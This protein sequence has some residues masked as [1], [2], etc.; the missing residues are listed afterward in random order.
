MNRKR[1]VVVLELE[2]YIYDI[3]TM[4]LLHTLDTG[5]NPSAICALSPSNDNSYLAYPAPIP[6][7]SSPLSSEQPPASSSQS[8]TIGSIM[9]FDTISLTAINMIQAHK[10]AIAAMAINSQGTMLATAS[11]KGTV[12][13]VFSV[14]D[15]KKLGEY[16]RGSKSAR[17]FSMN[18]NAVGSLLAVSSDTETVHVYNLLETSKTSKS[19]SGGGSSSADTHGGI[20]PHSSPASEAPSSPTLSRSGSNTDPLHHPS[21]GAQNPSSSSTSNAASSFSRRSF[22]LGKNLVAGMGGYLPNR[23]TEVWEPRRDFA[24]C[25][26]RGG[27]GGRSVVAMSP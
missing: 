26:L 6:S 21:G 18:F 10:S 12:I 24:F 9:I 22:H 23:V 3:S 11:D 15:A 25:K 5:P 8:S 14:P 27:G 2:I 4:K 1:L 20:I 19:K 7:A 17:V 13:R 16:R